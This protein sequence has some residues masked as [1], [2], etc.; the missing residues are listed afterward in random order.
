MRAGRQTTVNETFSAWQIAHLYRVASSS[1]RANALG[2]V[3]Q[4][5]C[6]DRTRNDVC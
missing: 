3:F 2:V 1:L 4:V 5:N 6:N